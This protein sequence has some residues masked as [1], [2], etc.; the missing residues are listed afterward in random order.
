M[1]TWD[2]AQSLRSFWFGLFI[3]PD[4]ESPLFQ[5]SLTLRS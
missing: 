1:Y 5:H 4:N 2:Q 3:I